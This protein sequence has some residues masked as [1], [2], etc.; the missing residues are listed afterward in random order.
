MIPICECRSLLDRSTTG[1]RSGEA[2]VCNLAPLT[3]LLHD[4]DRAEVDHLQDMLGQSGL[5]VKF[6][7]SLS[8]EWCLWTVFEH[9]GIAGNQRRQ[10][11]VDGDEPR[12]VPTIV[13]LG[14]GL[15]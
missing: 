13:V 2:D 11:R 14:R 12:V 9:D 8:H 10:Y 5:G 15:F 7:E 6:Q 1:D 3:D 4:L